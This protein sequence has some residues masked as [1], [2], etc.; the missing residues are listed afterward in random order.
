MRLSGSGITSCPSCSFDILT[1]RLIPEE[2]VK[3]LVEIPDS[4]KG[5]LKII[6]VSRMDDVLDH[7]LVRKLEPIASEQGSARPAEGR[8]RRGPRH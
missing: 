8:S 5:A 7:S 3:D 4:V 6:P 2:D 1:I